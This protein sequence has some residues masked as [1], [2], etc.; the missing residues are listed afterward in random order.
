MDTDTCEG[1]GKQ[2]A[3]TEGNNETHCYECVSASACTCGDCRSNGCD[4]ECNHCMPTVEAAMRAVGFRLEQMGGGCEA[5]WRDDSPTNYTLIT[6]SIADGS[7]PASFDEPV[8]VGT[9]G[10][11]HG[12]PL[13]FK[14]FPNLRAYLATIS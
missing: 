13:T 14:Q 1:C 2:N 6:S 4:P 12:E 3:G 10:H 11:E 9:Y 8:D 5:F 7:I